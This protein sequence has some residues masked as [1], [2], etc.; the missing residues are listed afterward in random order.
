MQFAFILT[1]LTLIYEWGK[2]EWL[3]KGR[4]I[5]SLFMIKTCNMTISRIKLIY[6]YWNSKFEIQ[7]WRPEHLFFQIN[8]IVIQVLT[9]GLCRKMFY[10]SHCRIERLYWEKIK[11]KNNDCT[12]NFTGCI[13]N[14][15]IRLIKFLTKLTSIMEESELMEKSMI[16]CFLL[17]LLFLFFSLNKVLNPGVQFLKR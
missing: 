4:N 9:T 8:D 3:F 13:Q 10:S 2:G 15:W 14:K 5:I 11:F 16:L 7:L 6:M 17:M 1:K 12:V